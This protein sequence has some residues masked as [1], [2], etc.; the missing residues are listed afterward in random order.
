M[1]DFTRRDVVNVSIGAAIAC[2][3]SALGQANAAD[4]TQQS[5]PGVSPMAIERFGIITPANAAQYGAKAPIED[6]P[7]ISLTTTHNGIVYVSGITADYNKPGNIKEQT[8]EV[9]GR[10]DRLLNKAGTDKSKILTATVWLTDMEN[11]AE[12]NVAWNA[13]VD[14]KNPPVRACLLSPQ[15]WWKGLLVEIMVT[16]AAS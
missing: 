14:A 2:G 9:L 4:V 13:W 5:T 8:T 15:L 7:I 11:F 1:A 6:I 10:I 12:H 3:A 16:A